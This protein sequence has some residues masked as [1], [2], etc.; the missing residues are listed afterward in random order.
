MCLA[1]NTNPIPKYNSFG[2]QAYITMSEAE[3]YCTLV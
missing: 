2:D 3:I 1:I